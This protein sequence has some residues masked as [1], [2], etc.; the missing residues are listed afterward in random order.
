MNGLLQNTLRIVD[1]FEQTHCCVRYAAHYTLMD[2][3]TILRL[4]FAEFTSVCI[5]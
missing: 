2:E 4:L 1:H 5:V 3:N